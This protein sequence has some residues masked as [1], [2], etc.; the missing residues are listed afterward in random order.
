MNHFNE[1]ISYNLKDFVQPS[2]FSKVNHLKIS[3]ANSLEHEIKKAEIFT[4]LIHKGCNV[5]TEPMLLD[6]KNRPDILVLDSVPMICYEIVCSE[7][8]ES[9]MRKDRDYPFVLKI[10]EVKKGVHYEI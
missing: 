3:K 2:E 4:K 6:N 10:V 5:L 8:E 7:K 1:I 9:L